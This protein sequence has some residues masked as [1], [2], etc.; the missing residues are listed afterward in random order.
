M[1]Y[2]LMNCK[3]PKMVEDEIAGRTSEATRFIIEATCLLGCQLRT[4]EDFPKFL[5]RL[6]MYQKIFSNLGDW[7]IPK[8]VVRDHIGLITDASV[9]SDAKFKAV[10]IDKLEE[11]VLKSVLAEH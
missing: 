1:N 2:S 8:S 5:L 3:N 4:D 11:L 7:V 10:I 9:F 6:R